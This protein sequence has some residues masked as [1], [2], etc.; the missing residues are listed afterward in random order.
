MNFKTKMSELNKYHDVFFSMAELENSLKEVLNNQTNSRWSIRNKLIYDNKNKIAKIDY[1]VV[2]DKVP[3]IIRHIFKISG[4]N[5]IIKGI[6]D[7]HNSIGEYITK[8]PTKDQKELYY[9]ME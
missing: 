3:N 6:T 5:F 8:Y 9:E 7:E 4:L 2:N 1:Y